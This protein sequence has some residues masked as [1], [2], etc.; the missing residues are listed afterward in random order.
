MDL[1]VRLHVDC[2]TSRSARLVF[3]FCP[4]RERWTAREDRERE[5]MAARKK[6]EKW[7]KNEILKVA[8]HK[9][10]KIDFLIKTLAEGLLEMNALAEAK[11]IFKKTSV[12]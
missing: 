8:V 6:K 2:S 5:K 4:E 11:T 9:V 7:P 1:I 3:S 12:K 10:L